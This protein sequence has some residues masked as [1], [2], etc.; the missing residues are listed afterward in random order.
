MT[1]K[2]EKNEEVAAFANSWRGRWILSQA[3][4]IAVD[5]LSKVPMPYREVSNINDMVYLRDNLFS[6]YEAA[7][8]FTPPAKEAESK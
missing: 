3:L 6:L 8:K 1:A 7:R 4:S 5:E 2:R